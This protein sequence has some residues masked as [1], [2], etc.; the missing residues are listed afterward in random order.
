[1]KKK[2]KTQSDVIYKDLMLF[3]QFHSYIIQYCNKN[4]LIK[5]CIWLVGEK[6]ISHPG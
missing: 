2:T 3:L 1:M 5:F 6:I 4:Y